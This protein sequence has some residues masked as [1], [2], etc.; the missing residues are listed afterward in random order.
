VD[1]FRVEQ[2]PAS[3]FRILGLDHAAPVRFVTAANLAFD[4]RGA[5]DQP[6]VRS[7]PTR[8][9]SMRLRG[10]A[11]LDLL[12]VS[13]ISCRVLGLWRSWPTSLRHLAERALHV[14]LRPASPCSRVILIALASLVWGAHRNL[15]GMRARRADRASRSHNSWPRFRPICCSPCGLPA[16]SCGS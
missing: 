10:P 8:R 12:W 9:S 2:E 13:L 6:P 14:C 1:R 7:A 5:L 3:A 16:S 15:V 11:S 4:R